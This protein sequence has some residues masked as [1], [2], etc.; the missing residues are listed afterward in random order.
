MTLKDSDTNAVSCAA[1]LNAKI[2]D[3]GATVDITFKVETTTEGKLYATVHN[4]V[5]AYQVG[6]GY[7]DNPIGGEAQ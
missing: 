1:K 5:D 2:G 3:Y 7:Q 4:L 6:V